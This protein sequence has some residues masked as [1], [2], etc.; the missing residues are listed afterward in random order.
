MKIE[1]FTREEFSNYVLGWLESQEYRMN[2]LSMN[3]MKSALANALAMIDDSQDG[4]ESYAERQRE[5]LVIGF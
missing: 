4:I 5:F 2:E 3:N 1:N